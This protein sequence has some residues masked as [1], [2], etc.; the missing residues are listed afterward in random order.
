VAVN[1][2]AIP[3]ELMESE[4]FGHVRG[5]FTDATRD[6]KGLA[7]EADGGTLFLDE[8]GELPPPLQ[9]KLLRFLQE[10]EV[11]PV[12]GT[13]AERVDVRVVA[14]TAR[15]LPAAVQAGQFREDLYYRL[16]VFSIVVPPLRERREDVLPIARRFLAERGLPPEKLSRAAGERLGAAPWPGNVRELHNALERALILAG[17]G[18]ILEE[19]IV[20]AAARPSRSRAG[21]V[22]GEGFNLDAFERELIH[23]ALARAA[24]NKTMAAQLLGITRRRL[25]SRLE[26]LA[27]RVGEV[28]GEPLEARP[29]G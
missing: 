11:R 12:G 20:P 13:R 7:V 9:V 22:L 4:L 5:A 1:C 2:G 27:A 8:I 21:D 24:G 14:A 19:H 18:E 6:K 29:R 28:D 26:S 17:G 15:D 23:T 16:D 3:A 10:E 25:Y